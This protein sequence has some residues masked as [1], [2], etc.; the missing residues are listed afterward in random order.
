MKSKKVKQSQRMKVKEE[1]QASKSKKEALLSNWDDHLP[2][3]E[4]SYNNS[5]H[6]SIQCAPY[7]AL[8][9]RKCRSPLNWLEV[10]ESRLIRPDIIQETTDKIKMVQEKLKAARDLVSA[11]IIVSEITR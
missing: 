9:G 5:Y 3:V 2:L 6:T 8:N 10:G 1:S 7:E 11:N 4:F